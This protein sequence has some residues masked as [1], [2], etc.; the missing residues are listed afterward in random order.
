[1]Q[2]KSKDRAALFSEAYKL[3]VGD[4]SDGAKVEQSPCDG[5]GSNGLRKSVM[6]SSVQ[7]SSDGKGC[8]DISGEV[9]KSSQNSSVDSSGPERSLCDNQSSTSLS[10]NQKF[11]EVS[12]TAVKRKRQNSNKGAISSKKRKVQDTSDTKVNQSNLPATEDQSIQSTKRRGRGRPPLCKS[13]GNG[14]PNVKSV[15]TKDKQQ[16]I[17]K[18]VSRKTQLAKERNDSRQGQRNV[19]K[20]KSRKLPNNMSRTKKK[21]QEKMETMKE[22]EEERTEELYGGTDTGYSE[23]SSPIPYRDDV[24]ESSSP[25]PYRDDV[26]ESSSPIPYRENVDLGMCLSEQTNCNLQQRSCVSEKTCLRKSETMDCDPKPLV[27][28]NRKK[29]SESK[30]KDQDSLPSLCNRS[31]RRK[32]RPQKPSKKMKNKKKNRHKKNS[33]TEE[34]DHNADKEINDNVDSVY[35]EASSPIPYGGH[36]DSEGISNHGRNAVSVLED[37]LY[38]PTPTRSF[39]NSEAVQSNCDAETNQLNGCAREEISRYH[40]T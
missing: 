3:A 34:D 23:S 27:K 33:T 6:D 29:S 10:E 22:I 25:I 30:A 38:L 35:T 28:F 31:I 17:T 39:I 15:K 18:A 13:S 32:G 36:V 24:S 9:L 16:R 21:H 5:K 7:S 11:K 14:V 19:G 26:S 40:H 2:N 8:T 37:S 4:I 20:T 1:M 12:L